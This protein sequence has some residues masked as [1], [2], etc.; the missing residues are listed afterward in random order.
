M[1]VYDVDYNKDA[2]NYSIFEILPDNTSVKVIER[3]GQPIAS[4]QD[5][6]INMQ[7]DDSHTNSNAE[8][9]NM[10]GQSVGKRY[11]PQGETRP[12]M[13]ATGLP[14]GI[15]NL[16]LNRNGETISSQKMLIK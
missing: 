11:I 5:G 15:Y 6:V 13:N 12:Q 8:L 9:F 16:I 10:S 14:D 4:A 1:Y 7:L 2:Y 3:V